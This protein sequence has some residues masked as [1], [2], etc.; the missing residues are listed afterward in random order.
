MEPQNCILALCKRPLPPCT[1]SL[2]RTPNLDRVKVELK[3]II[4][5]STFGQHQPFKDRFNN[6]NKI[7]KKEDFD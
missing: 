6:H 4:V 3:G 1:L 5:V 7:F 2:I